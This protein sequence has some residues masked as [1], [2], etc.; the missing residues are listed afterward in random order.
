MGLMP[1]SLLAV[2]ATAVPVSTT[3][4]GQCLRDVNPPLSHLLINDLTRIALC[5]PSREYQ[6]YDDV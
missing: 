4:R 1:E 3:A 6:N 2:T 5:N